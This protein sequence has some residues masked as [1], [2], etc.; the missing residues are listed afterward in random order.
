MDF[1]FSYLICCIGDDWRTYTNCGFFFPLFFLTLDKMPVD[2]VQFNWMWINRI[3]HLC[4]RF[5][6]GSK[7]YNDY[8][9]FIT[10][11]DHVLVKI[12]SF[13]LPSQL[14]RS[15][16][17]T[18]PTMNGEAPSCYS[19][20][21]SIKKILTC[22]LNFFFLIPVCPFSYFWVVLIIMA[23]LKLAFYF[24][25]F[26]SFFI[27]YVILWGP[28][29]WIDRFVCQAVANTGLRSGKTTQRI[30]IMCWESHYQRLAST[31]VKH[32]CIRAI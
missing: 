9:L 6:C 3:D 12:F 32:I 15:L 14:E 29:T 13:I 5:S 19:A 8:F 24:L 18:R 30:G 26:F 7:S 16:S 4:I 1:F 21:Q 31:G 2:W 22:Q 23:I 28:P 25:L 17:C 27:F 10:P 11:V 20:K